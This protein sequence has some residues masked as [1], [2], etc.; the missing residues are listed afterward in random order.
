MWVGG[1]T[2]G[3]ATVRP[4]GLSA[5][6]TPQGLS[7]LGKEETLTVPTLLMSVREAARLLGIGRD[8]AYALIREGR[9]PAIRIGRRILVPRA[10]LEPW[11]EKETG[12]RVA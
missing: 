9:L 11:V 5:T 7:P 6:R 12:G 8:S 10:A 1:S 3:A 2:H 4:D